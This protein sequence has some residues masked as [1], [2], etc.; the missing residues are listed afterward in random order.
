MTRQL[1]SGTEIAK[2]VSTH[3]MNME[4][5]SAAVN[6]LSFHSSGNYLLSGSDDGQLKVFDLLEGRL[7]YTLHGHQG[8]V[9]VWKTNFD[10]VDFTELLQSHKQRAGENGAPTVADIAPKVQR[11]SSA[12]AAKSAKG[13]R[14]D[15]KS[16]DDAAPEVTEIGPAMFSSNEPAS[17]DDV[18]MRSSDSRPRSRGDDFQPRSTTQPLEERGTMPPQLAGTLEH[19]VGQLDILT[20]TVSLLEQRLTMTEDKLRECLDN[21][22]QLSQQVRQK[23]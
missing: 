18:E 4:A 21:Q 14:S 1:N 13:G 11:P 10:Q 15:I 22:H 5:H 6:S 9:L 16:M 7:F 12:G 2:S 23:D 8:P 19:I 3:S 20:Q 17:F